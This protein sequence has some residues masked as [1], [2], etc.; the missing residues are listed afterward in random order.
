[1]EKF[2]LVSK[3]PVMGENGKPVKTPRMAAVRVSYEGDKGTNINHMIIE[4]APSVAIIITDGNQRIAFIKQFRST[5][6]ETY[7]ELPAGL[8]VAS[9]KTI[10]DTASRE[11]QEESGLLV[12]RVSLLDK[13]PNLL[14]PSKSNE[15]FGLAIGEVAG[16][17]DRNL[18]EQEAI[19]SKLIWLPKNEVENRLRKSI[20]IGKPFFDRLFLS[21]HSKDA[22]LTYFFLRK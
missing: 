12:K 17:V 14:D 8:L 15:D 20:T 2:R 13:S 1:M 5:T 21:G 18:D 6:G 19:S 16:Q 22:L 4:S 7:I 3:L 11:A 9:D 10:L